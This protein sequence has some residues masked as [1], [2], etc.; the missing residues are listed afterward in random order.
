VTEAPRLSGPKLLRQSWRLALLLFGALVAYVAIFA[1]AAQFVEYPGRAQSGN[2]AGQM[3]G[4]FHVHSTA[5]DGRG[6]SEEIALAA[7]KAGIQFV[8]VTDHNIETI[9]PARFEHGVLL[10]FGVEISS[11]AGH[12][13]AL[14][15]RGLSQAERSSDPIEVVHRLGGFSVVA[16]PI[17]KKRPWTD[18]RAARGADGLELYSADSMLRDSFRHPFARLL[19]AFGAYLTRPTHGLML[20][21]RP[22]SEARDR[23]FELSSERPKAALCAL[24]AHGLP[25]YAVEFQLLSMYLPK[26]PEWSTGWSEDPTQAAAT[27]ISDL[28]GGRAYCGFNLLGDANGF[29]IDG[30]EPE[31]REARAGT[32]LRVRLPPQGPSGAALRIW[33]SGHLQPDGRSVLLI[34]SGP[35]QIEVWLP[36]PG[37]LL[38][39]EWKPWIVASP[40][41]VRPA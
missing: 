5:S 10:I 1:V 29:Q 3:R 33:G 11:P 36:G 14:G 26:H 32:Q 17:Q 7:R 38:G 25:D 28:A 39:T 8:V 4:A 2:E 22:Q 37:K 15:S 9:P 12:L 13:V 24:D 16:H 20:L 34:G 21:V 6:T 18:W 31:V 40:I 27:V 41:W 19:P 35:V 30:L 23:L